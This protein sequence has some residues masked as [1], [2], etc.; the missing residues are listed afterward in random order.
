MLNH[1]V[2][3]DTAPCF[4]CGDPNPKTLP[5]MTEAGAS[6]LTTADTMAG[7]FAAL[8]LAGVGGLEPL[9]PETSALAIELR[10]C[11]KGPAATRRSLGVFDVSPQVVTGCEPSGDQTYPVRW[12]RARINRRLASCNIHYVNPTE[13]QPNGMAIGRTTVAM[14]TVFLSVTESIRQTLESFLLKPALRSRRPSPR[15]PKYVP[16]FHRWDPSA[17]LEIWPETSILPKPSFS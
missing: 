14:A 4:K 7:L 6:D 3:H 2:A 9:V 8:N 16:L 5:A 11:R 12:P 1:I 13:W 10:S 17:R 15:I